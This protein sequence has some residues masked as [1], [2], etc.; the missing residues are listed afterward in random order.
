M[1]R[2]D[3]IVVGGGHAGI[4]AALAAVRVGAR[5][6]LV[7]FERG[8]IGRMSCNPAIGGVAK[9]QI[10]REIDALG[11]AMGRLTDATGIQFRMLNRS[12]GAAVISPRAQA[13]KDAYQQAAQALAE[14]T[15]GLAVVE[16]EAV[17]LIVESLKR[18][19]LPGVH[20]RDAGRSLTLRVQ[21]SLLVDGGVGAFEVAHLLAVHPLVVHTLR[22]AGLFIP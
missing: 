6:C 5:T 1:D 13:D 16:G 17:E 4:E 14:S 18:A 2:F 20:A 10:V 22:L 8:G 21:I 7:T 12:K 3:V 15:E 19:P 11:G 9:G